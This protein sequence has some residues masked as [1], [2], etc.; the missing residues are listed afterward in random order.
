MAVLFYQLRVVGGK[1]LDLVLVVLC[2]GCMIGLNFLQLVLE[3]IDSCCATLAKCTLGCTVLGLS[4]LGCGR[5]HMEGD[6][7]QWLAGLLWVVYRLLVSSLAMQNG[8]VNERTN[9][10]E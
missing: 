4:L 6:R 3:L 10:S 7:M 8:E 1:L 9:H 5:K 2:T